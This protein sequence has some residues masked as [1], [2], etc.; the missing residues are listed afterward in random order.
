M[1]VEHLVALGEQVLGDPRP[2]PLAPSTAKMMSSNWDAQA[3][4]AGPVPLVTAKRRVALTVPS[5]AN[6]A[7]V[8][9]DLCGSIPM[10]V[11]TGGF[12]S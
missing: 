7:A 4:T 12:R 3:S 5:A 8:S 9:E 6:A 1:D 2:M 10:T 11:M